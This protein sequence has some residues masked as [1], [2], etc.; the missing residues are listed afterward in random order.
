VIGW[1]QALPESLANFLDKA[2]DGGL[3]SLW[4]SARDAKVVEAESSKRKSPRSEP[5]KILTPAPRLRV[6]IWTN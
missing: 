3:V 5:T 2:L 6:F 4:A 1:L